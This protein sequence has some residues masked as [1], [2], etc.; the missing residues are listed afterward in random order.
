MMCN[1]ESALPAA[2]NALAGFRW[3]GE[4]LSDRAPAKS[5][6]RDTSHVGVRRLDMP[7]AAETLRAEC[8]PELLLGEAR[9]RELV[10]TRPKARLFATTRLSPRRAMR[11]PPAPPP[12]R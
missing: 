7:L 6:P 5:T 8:D 11:W 4:G 10:L 3:P 12:G 2:A 1:A 9:R